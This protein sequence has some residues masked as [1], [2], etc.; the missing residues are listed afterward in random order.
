MYGKLLFYFQKRGHF[1]PSKDGDET[2]WRDDR[3]SQE[4]NH[5]LSA[6]Q[7][8]TRGRDTWSLA[9]DRSFLGF[10]LSTFKQVG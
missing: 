8:S 4:T 2:K 5:E 10:A 3:I 9:V 1:Q 6:K 7:D